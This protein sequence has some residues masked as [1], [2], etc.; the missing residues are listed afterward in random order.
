MNKILIIGAGYVGMSN[1]VYL[2]KENDVIFYDIDKE[3]NK[4]INNN[5]NYINDPCIKKYI[6]DNKLK[7]KTMNLNDALI[8]RNYIFICVPTDYDE[9]TKCLNTTLIESSIKNILKINNNAIIVIKSTIPINY[10]SKIIKKFNYKKIIY[11]P[12]FLREASAFDDVLNPSRII[13][14]GENKYTIKYKLDF[15]LDNNVYLCSSTEAEIIKLASNTYLAM[16]IAYFNEIDNLC[17]NLNADTLKVINGICSDQRIGN[18]Y[19]NPSFGYGG[20][21]LPKDSKE[22]MYS[23]KDI[24]GVLIE[25]IVKSNQLRKKEICEEILNKKVNKIGIYRLTSKSDSLNIKDSSIIDIISML[26]EN[27]LDLYIYEPFIKENTFKG[28]KVIKDLEIFKNECD[29]I[30]ANRIDNEIMD[31]NDKI[32]SKDIFY[33]D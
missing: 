7:L 17:Y 16:R 18:Y 9:N 22:L 1:G 20:Y 2:S 15:N 6:A 5:L 8:D 3:K 11:V 12:E 27:S 23:F 26:Q 10:T 25:A 21:C 30:I 28:I 14:G 31:I 13:I 33:R 19:N 29:L 32:F 24:P 4:L